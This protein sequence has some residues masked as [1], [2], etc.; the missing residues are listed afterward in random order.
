MNKTVLEQIPLGLS[1]E[2]YEPELVW[3]VTSK[4]PVPMMPRIPIYCHRTAADAAERMSEIGVEVESI[5]PYTI[6]YLKDFA[7]RHWRP[8][9]VL[10]EKLDGEWVDT[11]EWPV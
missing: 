1:Q 2:S 6:E 3:V 9:V 10:R 11:K 8:S 5:D 4:E 7:R